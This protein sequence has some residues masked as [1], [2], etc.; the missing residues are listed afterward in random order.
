[1]QF[2][3][4]H[5]LSKS[6]NVLF[7]L[8]L[9]WLSGYFL[10]PSSKLHQQLFIL[11]FSFSGIWLLLKNKL[12]TKDLFS[13][14]IFLISATYGSYYLIS[15]SWA[16]HEN[17]SG[18]LS[19]VKR[20]VLLFF[21]WVTLIY[22]IKIS[23]KKLALLIKILTGVAL[24]SIMINGILFYGVNGLS[25]ADR[26]TGIGRLWNALWSGAIYGAFSILI[27]SLLNWKFF[28]LSKKNRIFYLLAFLVFFVATILT[29]SR[30]PIGSMLIACLI[31]FLTNHWSIKWKIVTLAIAATF[32]IALLYLMQS[33]F[34]A[35]IERGQSYRLDLWKGFIEQVKVHPILGFGAGTQVPIYAPGEFTNE[36]RHYHSV[37]IGSLVELGMIG[38]LMHLALCASVLKAGWDYRHNLH[39]R[40]AL[41]L[42]IYTMMIGITFGQGIITRSNVQWILFWLPVIILSAIEIRRN[43]SGILGSASTAAT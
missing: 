26:F 38:L 8:S 4:R 18:Y 19:E 21:F 31:I 23:S 10:L 29:H 22:W 35:D 30:G 15:L 12:N 11:I 16:S 6:E 33:S 1:M 39:A 25:L 17:F 9:V 42:F 41:I 5:F 40:I 24:I 27:F 28:I 43:S 13:S 7:T 34:G 37:Y 36:W 32:S 14:G 20:V 3:N 2:L